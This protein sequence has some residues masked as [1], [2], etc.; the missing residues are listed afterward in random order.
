LRA[1]RAIGDEAL[2]VRSAAFAALYAKTGRPS[3]PPEKLMRALLLQAFY[4]VRSAP[5]R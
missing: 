1:I 4:S 5:L 3:I 2:E